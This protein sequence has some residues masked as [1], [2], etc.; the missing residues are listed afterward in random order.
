MKTKLLTFPLINHAFDINSNH[1]CLTLGPDDFLLCVPWSFMVLCFS[2]MIYFQLFVNIR[3]MVQAELFLRF[4]LWMSN[5]I[6]TFF[7][8]GYPS[9][10][11]LFLYLCEKSVG[12]FCVDWI[13]D[14]SIWR[15]E[16]YV[17]NTTFLITISGRVIAP[18][19]YFYKM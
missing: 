6:S 19:L 15:T 9:S 13:M 14:S 5:C 16:L 11:E 4:W 7:W 17:Y 2:S 18:T 1:L 3:C 8:K 12:H 10:T